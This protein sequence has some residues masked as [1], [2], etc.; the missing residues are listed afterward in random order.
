MTIAPTGSPK[1]CSAF[2]FARERRSSG[3]T[4]SPPST[5]CLENFSLPGLL[6]VTSHFDLPN[7]SEANSVILF[8]RAVVA[9]TV[10]EVSVCIG[11]LHAGVWK[12]SLPSQATVHPHRIFFND[13]Y[14]A[15]RAIRAA[16]PIFFWEDYGYWCLARHSD[17]SALLRDRRFGRQILHA[18]SRDELGWPPLEAHLA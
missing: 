7:S 8:T 4:L 6:T 17:V 15:Y 2:A 5:T 18:M 13:P 10:A 16:A 1:R 14:P 12:L 9:T 11:C 3:R